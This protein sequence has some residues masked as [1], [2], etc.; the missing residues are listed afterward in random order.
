MNKT[1]DLREKLK[2]LRAQPETNAKSKDIVKV[3]CDLASVLYRSNPEQ[4]EDYANQALALA[5]RTG[6][7]K[8]IADS[9]TVIGT[10]YWARG[11]LNDALVCY[12]RSLRI[13]EETKN[14]KGIASCYSNIG[15]IRRNQGDY[16][17]ALES[18]IKAL[19]IK[20]EITDKPGMAKS[21]N[22]IGIIYDE[23]QEYDQSLEYYFKAL[24]LFEELGD[25]QG[26]AISCNNIGVVL[27]SQGDCTRAIDYYRKSLGIKE[28]IG[29]EKG[30]ADSSMN[31]GTCYEGQKEY[32][33]ALAYCLKA[34]DIYEKIGD[35]RGIADS[36]NH[37][38]LIHTRLDHYDSAPIYLHK[39]LELSQTIG[40]KDWEMDS[41]KYLS[42]YY[43]TQ[44]DFGQALAYHM[45][46]STLRENIF[47]DITAEKIAQMNV[48]YDTEKKEK[49]AEIY[50][51]IFEN[52]VVGMYR[53][54]P[55]GRILMANSSLVNMLGYSSFIELAQHNIRDVLF[56]SGHQHFAF[57][58]HFTDKKVLLGLES[59][60]LKRDGTSLC[61]RESSR[62][63]RDEYGKV[64][65]YEGTVEDITERKRAE[66]ALRE[67]NERNEALL[68]AMPEMMFVLS[69]NGTYIDFKT[70]KENELAIAPGEIVG[71]NL[72]DAGFTEE[73]IKFI[74]EQIEDTLKTGKTHDFEY[75]LNI[76]GTNN[77]FDARIVPFGKDKILAT[78]RNVSNNKKAEE[79]FRK[80]QKLES[81][82]TLAGG[83]AHDFNNILTGLF[84]NIS[85]AK[86]KLPRNHP[87]FRSLEEA[88]N[89]MN[90]AIHLT[91]QLLT[92][93]KGGEPV[94]EDISLCELIREVSKFDLSGSNLKPVFNQAEDLWITK[95]DKGQMQ[96]VFS[97]LII[98][99]DQATPDGGHLYI[100]LENADISKKEVVNLNPGKY[101]KATIRDE[102]TGIDCKHLDRIFDPY[103]STKQAGSGL[104]LTTVYSIISKH[105]GYIYADSEL[106]TGTTFT[107]YLPASE[108][109]QL[110]ESKQTGTEFSIQEHTARILVMDDDRTIR[111][112]SSDMLN[113]YGFT[114]DTA[115]DGKEA[116]EK[117][118]SAENN[119]H[120]FDIV[121]MDLTIPGG[122]GGKEAVKEL[123]A[124]D[125]DAK[126]IVSSGYS[127]NPVLANYSEY[128]FIGRL[129]KP[130]I[131]A[132]LKNEL[133][134]IMKRE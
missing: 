63:V 93:A 6:F 118:I 33:S 83:I 18:H 124:I 95:A 20:E 117:Y 7:K 61:I 68:T 96:Q 30:I 126:V 3:L 130:F 26:I 16:E 56:D 31:I 19:T 58:E 53:I 85:I 10:S 89:S 42:E 28:E 36:N 87:G 9:I 114:V 23:W 131:I 121:I 2:V 65:Y 99:A 50:R 24:R 113:H 52:T 91:R 119:G 71:K 59:I 79:E 70:E 40:A 84:G 67:S 15:N 57:S 66:N 73:R 55:E 34:M 39:G 104:G 133:M 49:E 80:L 127:M 77:I 86:M 62:A 14:R 46:Y 27:E 4:A 103:F 76:N 48:K 21:Y 112:V 125:P 111:D 129:T 54:T 35:K 44:G 60:W 97:N 92:F 37:I 101:I 13:C 108:S 102:G 100:T 120:P 51:D 115:S 106:G 38:G 22:N 88:E 78:V 74:L 12:T 43:Q 98:N 134:R 107:L 32:D 72:S 29:D 94:R 25:K 11:D 75:E 69:K 17:R 41:Y 132:D 116:I 123:L 82:G 5:E 90:R 64:M 110:P 105:G 47:S 81:I 109:G 1:E 128:G 45:K 8:G 122:M